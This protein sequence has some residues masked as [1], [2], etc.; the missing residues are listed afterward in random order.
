MVGL[1]QKDPLRISIFI[2]ALLFCSWMRPFARVGILFRA[3]ISFRLLFC[4]RD[5]LSLLNPEGCPAALGDGT[6]GAGDCQQTFICNT[7]KPVSGEVNI[8]RMDQIKLNTLQSFY[9]REP[10]KLVEKYVPAD[11]TL[12]LVTYGAFLEYPFFR[13]ITAGGWCRLIPRSVLRMWTG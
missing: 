7:G 2:L 12:G 4:R 9:M 11:A 13:E 5:C 10:V 6:P 1:K 8:W 3:V